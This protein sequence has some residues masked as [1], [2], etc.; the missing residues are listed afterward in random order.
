LNL[1]REHPVAKQTYRPK[2]LNMSKVF[3]MLWNRESESLNPFKTLKLAKIP[4]IGEFFVTRASSENF[5]TFEVLQVYN[6][7][8]HPEYGEFVIVLEE[9]DRN[10]DNSSIKKLLSR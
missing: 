9:A 1:K 3:L 4:S 5:E 10:F 8:D 6:M 2:E 7:I